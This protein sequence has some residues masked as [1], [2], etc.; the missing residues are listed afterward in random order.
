MAT[1]T[2]PSKCYRAHGHTH[3]LTQTNKQTITPFSKA[4]AVYCSKLL[5]CACGSRTSETN[6]SQRTQSKDKQRQKKQQTNNWGQHVARSHLIDPG[7]ILLRHLKVLSS[8]KQ[9]EKTKK[10]LLLK[11]SNRPRANKIMQARNNVAKEVFNTDWAGK[12]PLRPVGVP[13]CFVPELRRHMP[14][15]PAVLIDPPILQAKADTRTKPKTTRTQCK[16]KFLITTSG[17]LSKVPKMN[18]RSKNSENTTAI[19]ARKKYGND[20][21]KLQGKK[22]PACF[23]LRSREPEG[24]LHTA[25]PRKPGRILSKT[26]RKSK[27]KETKQISTNN[28]QH[29]KSQPKSKARGLSATCSH[30]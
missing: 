11:V 10:V 27:R 24:H 16:M 26:K 30:T 2:S 22:T 12:R 8:N 1:M 4:A 14:S 25:R 5:R 9:E 20:R 15:G 7:H 19:S 3:T 18:P 29:D 21:T 28:H 13:F 6:G 23:G 17:C